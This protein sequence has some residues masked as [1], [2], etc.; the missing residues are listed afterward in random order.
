MLRGEAANKK[1][2][3]RS[4]P[5]VLVILGASYPE[6]FFLKERWRLLAGERK[7]DG[8]SD[9]QGARIKQNNG[10]GL[11]PARKVRAQTSL[12]APA[13]GTS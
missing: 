4:T 7:I 13:V 8:L 10:N 2:Q 11:S 12:R 3:K 5:T 9:K 1:K 6:V